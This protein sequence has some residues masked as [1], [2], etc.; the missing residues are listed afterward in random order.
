MAKIRR[1]VDPPH[2]TERD[3][4]LSQETE[5]EAGAERRVKRDI[6]AEAGIDQHQSAKKTKRPKDAENV[7][8]ND[9]VVA[10]RKKLQMSA[11]RTESMKKNSTM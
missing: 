7:D 9:V 5:R 8:E 4:D 10:K 2:E 11:P 6:T 1:E 3:L